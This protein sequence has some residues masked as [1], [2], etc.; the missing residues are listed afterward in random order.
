MKHTLRQILPTL[1]IFML[2]GCV[3]ST[4][5]HVDIK[6]SVSAAHELRDEASFLDVGIRVF[7]VNIPEEGKNQESELDEILPAVRIAESYYMPYT[8]KT[9]LEKSG[10]WG[11]VRVL[12][13]EAS[14]VDVNVLGTI[15]KSDGADL[16]LKIEVKDVT[17]RRWF[18]K[19]YKLAASKYNYSKYNE[20]KARAASVNDPFVTLYTKIA[21]DILSHRLKLKEA[22]IAEIRRLSS[23]RF[24]AD[25]VPEIY[26][27]YIK[28]N[29]KGH[30]SATRLPAKN[31][32]VYLNLTAIRDRENMFVDILDQHYANFTEKMRVP[33][34]DWRQYSYEE[35]TAYKKLRGQSIR[36]GLL[37]VASIIG[38]IFA[39]G[40]NDAAARAAGQIAVVGGTIGIQN[41]IA[42]GNQAKIHLEGIKE[43]GVGFEANI[44][45]QTLQLRD[46]IV[47]LS[48]S[49]EQQYAT[50]R[51][52]LKEFYL[53]QIGT[54]PAQDA[55][56]P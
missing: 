12:P 29:R 35:I 17:E 2:G 8:L 14:P 18:K 49:V 9:V 31:D 7:S 25:F 56:G 15:I 48:G 55:E 22:R 38:G 21:D 42:K 20:S 10:N 13:E 47:T 30:Q 32:P 36:R 11:L 46:R 6:P 40:S 3:S 23:L 19:T 37:G 1:L 4:M 16:E 5:N 51:A 44:E 33:Y 24:A 26:G 27:D 50:W 52:L 28:T 53:N 45:P 34:H 54:I 39:A 41:S 43:L